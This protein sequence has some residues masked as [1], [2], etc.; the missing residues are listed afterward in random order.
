M[1]APRTSRWIL[2]L[3]FLGLAALLTA[4]HGEWINFGPKISARAERHEQILTR[5]GEA[6]WVY[7][8]AVPW[9]AEGLAPVFEAA[10]YPHRRALEHGYLGLR[11]VFTWSL[12]L[13][14]YRWLGRWLPPPW[15]LV[16]TLLL[17]ALHGPSYAFYWFQPDSALD[18]ALWA[19]AL[20]LAMS[21]RWAWVLPLMVLGGLN[22]ETIAFVPFLY[23]AL[24]WDDEPR[25]RL[26]WQVAAML[27][28][29]GL[30]VLV[31]RTWVGPA[32]WAHGT[33]PLGMLQTNLTHGDWLGY[34]LLFWGLLWA[35]PVLAWRESPPALRRIALVLLPYL[36]LQLLFGRIR[37]VRLLLPL[38]VALVPM[39]LIWL[40]ARLP[41]EEA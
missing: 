11:L 26:A 12:F 3:L 37:E 7:R 33:T 20:V 31:V 1:T 21:G 24:R 41:R 10:G 39:G 29:G 32:G 4:L 5:S 17:A 22:R 38:A 15:P 13:L 27:L 14:F 18:L 9:A 23:A 25:G 34:A 19:G 36:L 8:V 40:K 2:P 30:A 16:G 35:A 28:A 6:P